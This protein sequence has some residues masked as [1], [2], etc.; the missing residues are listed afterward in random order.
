VDM[1]SNYEGYASTAHNV[2]DK[3]HGAIIAGA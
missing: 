3:F 1:C 2:D